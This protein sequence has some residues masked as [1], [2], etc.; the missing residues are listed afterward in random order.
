V[1]DDGLEPTKC[2]LVPGG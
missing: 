1:F 2:A